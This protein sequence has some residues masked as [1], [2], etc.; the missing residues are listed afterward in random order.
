MKKISILFVDARFNSTQKQRQLLRPIAISIKV[1]CAG[2]LGK[3]DQIF[4]NHVN[5]SIGA[6]TCDFQ[7]FG[8]LTSVN[9]DEPV[10]PPFKFR[11]PN[12]VQS[13]A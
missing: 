5:S 4:Y 12:A 1:S 10:L 6:A 13:V 3:M 9:S 11:T 2:H 7:Q 8:I